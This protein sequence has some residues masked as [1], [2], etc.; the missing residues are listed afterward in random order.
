ML[1]ANPFSFRFFATAFLVAMI[2]AFISPMQAQDATGS[3]APKG[4]FVDDWTYHHLLFSNPGTREDAVKNGELDKWLK[5][6]SDPR[7]QMQQAKRHMGTP[8]VVAATGAF[9]KSEKDNFSDG[10]REPLMGWNS[11]RT[12]SKGVKKDW[13]QSLGSVSTA[14]ALTVA[15]GTLSSSSISGGSQFTI[16][17]MTFDASAPTAAS[18]TGTFTGNPTSGQTATINGV[19]L[20]A[21][22]STK[23]TRTGTFSSLPQASSTITVVNGATLSL[24][25][26]A[27]VAS[28]I[29]TVAA[30]PTS[31]TAPTIAITNGVNGN[32]LTLTTNATAAHATGTITASSVGPASGQTVKITNGLNS[33]TL[34]LTG[35]SGGT[36]TITV[37]GRPGNSDTLTIGATEYTFA[38]NCGGTANCID[39]PGGGGTT[40]LEYAQNIAAA[41]TATSSSCGTTVPCYGTGT[42]AVPNITA[43]AATS[44]ASGQVTVTNYSGAAL[45][46]SVVN[47]S[48]VFTLSP[49]SG[50]S[51]AVGT[52]NTCTG[53]TTGTFLIDPVDT[54][55]DTVA[56]NLNSAINA[57]VGTY[58]GVGVTSTVASNVVTITNTTLGAYPTLTLG[59]GETATHFTWS[60]VTAG[61]TGTNACTSST[62]GTF[63]TA[64]SATNPTYQVASNL[65]AA[66]MSTS[67]QTTYPVGVTASYASGN[68]FTVTNPTPGPFLTVNATNNTGIFSWATVTGGNAGSNSCTSSTA[69]TYAT[70]SSTTTLAGNLAAAINLCPAAVGVTASSST[71]TV[72]L[73]AI[74]A[75]TAGNSIGLTPSTAGF[76]AW[77]GGTL[78][79]GTGTNTGT[80]FAV[81]G[82]LADDATNLA[83]A[84]TRN[85]STT[86]LTATSSA[87]VVT[88]TA[89][90]PGTGADTIATTETLSNFAWQGTTLGAG[91]A[92]TNGTTSGTASPP[93]FAYWTGTTYDA[94]SVVASNITTAVNANSTASAVITAAA[95]SPSSGDVTFTAKTAG[96]AGNSY[97]ASVTDFSALTGAVSFDGGAIP[98]VQ[99]NAYPAKY[100]ASLT[101]ASCANDFVVYPAGQAGGTGAANIIAYNN[102]YVGT[103]AC[104][105]SNPT[106]YWAY[107]AGTGHAVTNSPIISADGTQVAFMQSNGANASLV[108]LKWK[109]A[110]SSITSPAA[111]TSETTSTY[112]ACT[113]PCMVVIPLE[114]G[115]DDSISAP[116]YDYA[117][118][119]ALYVGDDSG[120]LHQFKGV[121]FG[122]PEETVTTSWPVTLDAGYKISSPIY[123]PTSGYVFVGD[124]DGTL[125][126]VGTGNAGTTT[127]VIHGTANIGDA[128]ADAPLVDSNKGA[129]FAFVTTSGSYSEPGANALYGFSTAFTDLVAVGQPG[130]PG[131]VPLGTGGTGYYLY[132]GMFDNVW[133]ESST[134][135][136]NLYVA[137]NTGGTN[138]GAL[139]KVAISG[140]F[141]TGAWSTYDAVLTPTGAHPY[142]SPLSEFCN[143]AC[144][145]SATETTSGTDYVFFSLNQSEVGGCTSSA[146]H[147][148]ILSFNVT[149]P[150]AIAISGTGLNVT[151][152][153]SPGCW[154]TGGI[155]VD[156]DATTTGASQIYLVNL[157]GAAAGG[158]N[159]STSSNCAAGSAVTI[160]AVQAQQSNP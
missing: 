138:T 139:Y 158:P 34:T 121:F 74:T 114:D 85:I 126:S 26:N 131:V 6:T 39:R 84:I 106:V 90:T 125:H 64:S 76:F 111:I 55:G 43:T 25:T 3:S 21:S 98:T 4:G 87:G 124:L 116:F 12:S 60:T 31:T 155:V 2:A 7:Y 115:D 50:S 71:K 143:G 22:V 127:G 57:C 17:G 141:M 73:T 16:D 100:G 95:N 123:D 122:T 63:A 152:P 157:D 105:T 65:E 72:T 88:V 144:T 97:S 69:G 109:S 24:T 102:I 82:V 18:E 41:I 20:T 117:S 142:P 14:A 38:S 36:G 156:N 89:A 83:A 5:V 140:G 104:E 29:G 118:D 135:S 136:G 101:T 49:A 27:T 56:G 103:G 151:T 35:G 110:T 159:G 148:C 78:T 92:G 108:L 132:A 91:T 61:A 86:V 13:S 70:S 146:G 62:T 32:V 54:T 134:D 10:I 42:T 28:A 46:W 81:D 133:F 33:N 153:A 160:D 79:G 130:A 44:G 11:L 37:S 99:P 66:I 40:N 137:G 96:A 8:P 9:R 67:C 58:S 45:T 52:T 119:D 147:G 120:L 94:A 53:A 77:A 149:N 19:A 47:N 15:V 93:T 48:G 154:A 113:A 128:I 51:I 145:A 112:R 150:S 30:S 107:N 23:A 68:T 80:D 75:G 1:N 129:V 59:T